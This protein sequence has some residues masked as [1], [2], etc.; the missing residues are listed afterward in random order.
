MHK[1]R[2]THD[3]PKFQRRAAVVKP[4]RIRGMHPHTWGKLGERLALAYMVA[5]G[6]WPLPRRR[7]PVQVD[8]LVKRSDLIVLL[9]V[10]TRSRYNGLDKTLS[11]QQQQ[12]LRAQAVRLAAYYPACTVRIDVMVITPV[13]PFVRYFTNM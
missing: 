4:P 9:E 6:F 12:R 13:W 11:F 5:C 3:R 8:V 10:K 1:H 7:M 2:F